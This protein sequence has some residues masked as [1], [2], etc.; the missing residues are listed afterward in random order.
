MKAGKNQPI[1]NML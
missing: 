1:S